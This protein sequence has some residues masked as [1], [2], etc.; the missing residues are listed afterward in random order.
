M[1]ENNFFNI[2]SFEFLLSDQNMIMLVKSSRVV[3]EHFYEDSTIKR[4]D[5]TK[6]SYP[7]NNRP[8]HER[9]SKHRIVSKKKK[10]SF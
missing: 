8:D 9:L 6:R 7:T 10:C 3:V 5:S 4:H 1:E 2:V